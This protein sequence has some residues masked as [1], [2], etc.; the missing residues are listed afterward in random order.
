MQDNCKQKVKVDVTVK[1]NENSYDKPMVM[2]RKIEYVE[3]E[4][5]LQVY[6]EPSRLVLMQSFQILC[7][8]NIICHFI[9]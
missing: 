1:S 3:Q 9:N 7:C 6:V 5:Q 8:I 4:S 2:M